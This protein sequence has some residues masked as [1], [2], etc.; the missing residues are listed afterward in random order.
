MSGAGQPRIL[1]IDDQRD[2][3]RSLRAA[4]ERESPGCIVLD[5][6]SGEEALLELRR[7]VDLLV[8]AERLP[9]MSGIEL[10]ARVRSAFPGVAAILLSDQ[11]VERA[12][13]ALN[14]HHVHAIFQRPADPAA[15]AGAVNRALHGEERPEPERAAPPPEPQETSPATDAALGGMLSAL[16]IDLGAQGACLIAG[17]GVLLVDSGC[18]A[19]LPGFEEIA[20]RL[21]ESFR[22]AASVGEGLGGDSLTLQVIEGQQHDLCA[23]SAGAGA[24][25]AVLFPGGASRR[26]MGM[27]LRYGRA[28][29]ERIAAMMNGPEPAPAL[30]AAPEVGPPLP[31]KPP[32]DPHTIGTDV[33]M[34]LSRFGGNDDLPPPP[35][36]DFAS[37]DDEID[38]APDTDL[39]AFWEQ[40]AALHTKVSDDAFSLDEAIELGL[41][42]GEDGLDD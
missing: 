9:G 16:R 4:L 7:G 34:N 33:L 26:Q 24:L 17:D 12:E 18:A 23:L 22:A 20:A 41:F 10:L 5:M 29:A 40:A 14:G 28:T 31:Q 25:I 36:I 15:V 27:V 39:D 1:I 19:T 37:L 38:S 32:A 35:D 8:V 11:P 6:P 30:A 3:A 13:A 42:P 2:T 21:A